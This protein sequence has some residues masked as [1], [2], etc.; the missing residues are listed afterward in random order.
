MPILDF[1][2][3]LC[4]T[5]V[6]L[7]VPLNTYNMI[8]RLLRIVRVYMECVFLISL[9]CHTETLRSSVPALEPCK[10]IVF[11][12]VGIKNTA[13]SRSCCDEN[14]GKHAIFTLFCDYSCIE[15]S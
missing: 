7:K 2:V 1:Q 3:H 9:F 12:E 6:F 10:N 15:V 14:M 11:F 13:L 4:K 8:V 5:H